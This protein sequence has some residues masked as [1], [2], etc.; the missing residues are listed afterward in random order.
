ME[1]MT[2]EQ[3][4]KISSLVIGLF[5]NRPPTAFL[6]RSQLQGYSFT[7]I[8]RAF[9]LVIAKRRKDASGDPA[10]YKKCFD[11]A[12]KAAAL[13]ASLHGPLPVLPDELADKIDRIPCDSKTSPVNVARVRAMND[14][15]AFHSDEHDPE[16]QRWLKEESLDS[17]NK[18]C[19]TL[20]VDD[21][22]YWRKIYTHLDPNFRTPFSSERVIE[23]INA[24]F[25]RAQK[26]APMWLRL[27]LATLQ[28]AFFGCFIVIY[29]A[30]AILVLFLFIWGIIW[31][32]QL[33]HVVKP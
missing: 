2:V 30:G 3:A 20:D 13:V 31:L 26:E 21:P 4:D 29:L 27:L 19:W 16:I 1:K 15:P 7:D 12:D 5:T 25:F 28:M 17:F 6:R 8:S 9:A 18:F 32:F 33:F 11:Y 23:E 10:M 24:A 14:D 22:L